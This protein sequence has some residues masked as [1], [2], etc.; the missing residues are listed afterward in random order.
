MATQALYRRWRPQMFD[1]VIGQDHVT[2]TLRNA[3]ATERVA[4]AYLFT[5][6]RGTGKTTIARILAKAVNCLAPLDERPCNECRICRAMS[7]GS[8]LDLIE[9]DAASNTGVDDVR[10]LREKINFSPNEARQKVYVID[11]V[12]ML[13]NA[14]FNALLKT[15]EEPPAHALFVLATTEPHKIPETIK[16]RCQRFDFRRVGLQS[17]I[18]KLERICGAE[19][20]A[21]EPAALEAIARAATGSL[22]DSESLLDQ[23]LAFAEGTITLQQVQTLLGSVSGEAV[24]TLVDHLID[25]NISDG[26]AL[27]NE[28]V[29]AGADPRQ[30]TRQLLEYLRSLLLLQAGDRSLVNVTDATL[31][32]LQA[33]VE[34]L[35]ARRLLK[36]I[37]CFSEADFNLKIGAQPQLPLELAFVEMTLDAAGPVAPA[38]QSTPAIREAPPHPQRTETSG[39][40]DRDLSGPAVER[41]GK[42]SSVLTPA[43]GSV[44]SSPTP[45]ERALRGDP[46]DEVEGPEA[47]AT[48]AEQPATSAIDTDGGPEIDS[49]AVDGG[50]ASAGGGIEI[51]AVRDNWDELL[52]AIRPHS[53][54]V[55]ALL[56][57][58]RPIAVEGDV[59]T[60]AFFYPFHRQRVEEPKNK[61]LVTA[62]LERV[63]GVRVRVQCVMIDKGAAA[64][65]V[66]KRRPKDRYQ[67]AAEDPV[68]QAAVEKF[69]ARIAGIESRPLAAD[70]EAN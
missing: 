66:Q 18:G 14:A 41:S 48:V 38:A 9:I 30:F 4:H 17:I 31:L 70:E 2:Q 21:V 11:E 25:R 26:L 7:D 46:R 44:S 32:R 22:R 47:L 67:Q 55:E 3:L 64:Q 23:L 24:A 8:H 62:M 35:P 13:S 45:K 27:I 61:S 39:Q 28:T 59:V 29:D 57:D 5:G 33:Q 40:V 43:G 50:P 53:R 37:R 65:E 12:H 68:I 1:D 51:S 63:L 60:L 10:D 56:K 52:T 15:L 54:M 20:V 69:G 58:C 42:S 34:S 49:E 6:P 19:G 36:I 16:S